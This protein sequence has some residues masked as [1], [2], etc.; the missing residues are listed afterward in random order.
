M[1]AP[2]PGLPASRRLLAVTVENA[3]PAEWEIAGRPLVYGYLRTA[4]HELATVATYDAELA[5]RCAREGW[6]LVTVFPDVG[7]AA[8]VLIRPD[9]NGPRVEPSRLGNPALAKLGMG[10]ATIRRFEADR[11]SLVAQAL[12]TGATPEQVIGALG[13]DL[14]DLRFAIGR[15]EANLRRQ[16]QLTDGQGAD[17]FAIVYG[18]R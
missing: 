17:L 2:A 7:I 12:L 8:E 15:W 1:R 3:I 18:D 5:T 13:W 4:A 6:Q 14:A 11:P 9:Q 10:A 16:G